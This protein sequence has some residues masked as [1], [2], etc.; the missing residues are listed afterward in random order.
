MSIDPL[1]KSLS[2]SGELILGWS[3]F[4]KVAEFSNNLFHFIKKFLI[5]GAGITLEIAAAGRKGQWAHCQT[6]KP[7][8]K[9]IRNHFNAAGGADIGAGAAADADG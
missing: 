3:F 4:S 7:G 8:V 6:A 1:A 2:C 5:L 9:F